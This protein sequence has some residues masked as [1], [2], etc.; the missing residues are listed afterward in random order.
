MD[1]IRRNT[2]YAIRAMLNL[3]QNHRR[4]PVSTNKLA[5]KEDI[6]YQ[7]A[8]KLMQRLQKAGFIRSTM[9]PAGGFM[10]EKDSSKIRLLDVIVA[11]QGPL[12]VNRC[13]EDDKACERSPTCPVHIKLS[14]LQEYLEDFLAGVSLAELVEIGRRKKLRKL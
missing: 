4:E 10:L 1:I 11:I 14:E 5:V 9:G 2:D 8:C 13:L 12:T 3:G 7:L 6:S